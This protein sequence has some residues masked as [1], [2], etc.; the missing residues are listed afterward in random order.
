MWNCCK[1]VLR[2]VLFAPSGIMGTRCYQL[3]TV[4]THTNNPR[5]QY[6]CWVPKA[7]LSLM[8]FARHMRDDRC[9]CQRGAI[10]FPGRFSLN[11]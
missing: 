9:T 10:F 1:L 2:A 5:I 11:S 7:L 4:R 3:H 8:H 6:N